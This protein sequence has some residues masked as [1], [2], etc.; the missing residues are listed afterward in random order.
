MFSI[1]AIIPNYN[2]AAY[3]PQRI[4]SV[5]NQTL[6][7]AELLILDDC[8]TD[9]SREII[10]KYARQDSRIR[11]LFNEQ[12]SGSPFRQWAKGIAACQGDYVWIA[13]SDD[14][15]DPDFLSKTIAAFEHHPSAGMAYS[16]SWV[17]DETGRKLDS[18][19]NR[20]QLLVP[21]LHQGRTIIEQY[22]A[23][24]NI[25]PNASAVVFRRKIAQIENPATGG[26]ANDSY[27]NF[28]FAGDWW[29]WCQLLAVSDLVYVDEEL[30]YFR[31]HPQKVTVAAHRTATYVIESLQVLELLRAKGWVS[32]QT[33]V[34]KSKN[35][36]TQLVQ[37]RHKLPVASLW[38]I[39][40][41]ALRHNRV[42]LRHFAKRILA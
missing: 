12:N 8:S 28:R 21:G 31:Q 18:C 27:Q 30:N 25:I 4:E 40:R 9:N 26:N 7:A 36:A 5:L 1:S 15:A 20:Y 29:F 34:N 6:P 3:L 32:E 19:R 14:Y 38:Q 41:Y 35:A 11:T 42:F 13:E 17:V 10:E 33:F 22:L 24:A 2:H 16:Q 23:G 37:F 39:M